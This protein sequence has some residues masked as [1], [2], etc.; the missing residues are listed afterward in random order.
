M[1]TFFV[2][3]SSPVGRL[4]DA[5]RR[6]VHSAPNFSPVPTIEPPVPQEITDSKNWLTTQTSKL[7]CI[8]SSNCLPFQYS[9][10]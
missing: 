2:R 1:K 6:E 10:A 3:I 7:F 4:Q 9:A 8:E 5:L